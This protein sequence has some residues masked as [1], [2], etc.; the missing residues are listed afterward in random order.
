[1][2]VASL[3]AVVSLLSAAS[4]QASTLPTLSIAVTKSSIAVTGPT[5][6]GAVN[7]VTTASGVKEGTAILLLIRP[8]I[9]V[10]EIESVLA[11]GAGGKDPNTTSKYGTI[12]FSGEATPNRSEE[13]QIY[14]Q[15][16]QY[17]ALVP[18]HHGTGA[19]AHMFFTVT[20]AASPLALATPQATIRTIEFGFRGPTTLHDGELVRFENEG[21][22]IHMDIAIPAK[23]Q[24]AAKQVVKDLLSGKEKGIEK[25]AT[26]E[27]V[28]FAP[29]MSHEAFRQEMITEKPGWYV[30]A[31]FMETQDR[32]DHTRLGME[33]IIKIV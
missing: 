20:A 16:G 10:A 1:M 6:S 31:C 15:P 12:V 27:P 9:T 4:A 30:Q 13:A 23:S 26:G 7:V 25:L 19:K 14:L 22:L 3:L 33:R 32:R 29:P 24:S 21:F 18:G 8:G 28:S 2:L 17:L 5:Q 11:K